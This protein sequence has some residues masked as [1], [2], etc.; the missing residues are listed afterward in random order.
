MGNVESRSILNPMRYLK[1]KKYKTKAKSKGSRSSG[2][3]D[4]RTPNLP[5]LS[6]EADN[7]T[8]MKSEKKKN[9]ETKNPLKRY[10]KE[11]KSS[12]AQWKLERMMSSADAE[13]VLATYK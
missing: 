9:K 13:L 1:R 8:I 10:W 3:S 12:Q 2:S 11:R 4:A 5:D 7:S 6:I